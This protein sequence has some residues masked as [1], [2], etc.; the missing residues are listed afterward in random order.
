MSSIAEDEGRKTP[1]TEAQVA[2]RFCMAKGCVP[3]PGVNNAEQAAEVAGT[4]LNAPLE[5][6]E[7]EALQQQALR[8]HA[9]RNELPWLRSL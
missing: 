9:R 1:L 4:M 5:I 6:D 8:L 3:I 2:L 7:I